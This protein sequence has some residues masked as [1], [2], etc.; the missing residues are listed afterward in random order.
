M[1]FWKNG[2]D[3][4]LP[5]FIALIALQ[6]SMV[7]LTIDAML[8]ALPAI[9]L[10]LGVAS[11]NET[12]LVISL[13]F[14]GFAVGQF[15]YGPLSDSLGRKPMILAGIALFGVG[16][17]LSLVS[18]NYETML[19][20]RVLQG[21]G[22]AG[23]RT[24]TLAVVRDRYAGR[25]MARIMSFV[26]AVFIVVPAL[27][28]ALGQAVLFIADW[29]AIF[30]FLMALGMFCAIWMT[31]R[32]PE[33][34]A[35]SDRMPLSLGRIWSAILETVTNRHAIGYT[36]SAGF[37]F[38][39]FV[40]YLNSAQQIFQDVFG[41]GELFP[42]FFGI[43]ALSIG[44]SSVVNARIVM[45]L[46]MRFLSFAAV[47]ALTGLSLFFLV[48]DFLLQG[49]PPLWAFMLWGMTS[50]FCIGL[51]FGNLNALAMEPLGH[52]AGTGSAVVGAL[53]TLISLVFGIVVGQA[54]DGTVMPLVIGFAALGVISS[55][56][57]MITN[58]G[59][60]GAGTQ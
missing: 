29:R 16:C 10:E 41:L 40:G 48:V 3:Q 11:A 32:L 13:F 58:R 53:T 14:L 17:I 33:T 18:W 46:G 42:L 34:L 45:R 7:A 37:I 20:G 22:A 57:M 35:D 31:I 19:L 44:A 6:I 38:G 54:F 59:I 26:M 8:P 36:I 23:P 4:S 56:A 25:G 39:A 47:F 52:I 24:V 51:L 5:E 12:Q 49:H 60:R 2:R 30:F 43:L 55:I 27:A 1:S 28:P 15:F 9:G 21:L 50:F